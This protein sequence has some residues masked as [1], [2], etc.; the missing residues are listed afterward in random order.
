M[1]RI[2]SRV[3][4]ISS[5]LSALL[6]IVVP[7]AAQ[8]PSDAA[9]F[10]TL[11]TM[12]GPIP[13]ADRAQPANL[14]QA[15]DLDIL[16][17]AGDG[18]VGQLAR[19]GVSATS[20]DAV[21]ISHL[22]FDHT[23]GLLAL[24]GLYQQI[25]VDRELSIYG[26]PGTGELVRGLL[27]AMK[28]AAE[29]GPGLPNYVARTPGEHIRTVELSDGESVSIGKARL[30]VAANSHYSYPPGSADAKR[31]QSLSLR[32]D[33][34]GRSIVY[35]GD[36]GPSTAVEKLARGADLLVCEI[37]DVDA[38]MASLRKARPSMPATQ[39]E[40]IRPHF[41]EQHLV[42]DEIGLLASRARVG[43]LV[44]THNPASGPEAI[45]AIRRHF[46]GPVALASDLDRF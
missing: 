17:D 21:V 44:I 10:V 20:I 5:V 8:P 29:V 33:L 34:P 18:A 26:P 23:A 43:Q 27:I 24:L 2:G 25:G 19:A 38:A 9:S 6:L 15:G 39:V 35:T 36:T 46:S 11:G 42:A 4:T 16:V 3:S 32:F 13:S 22:H 37:V 41:A 31:F 12:G 40:A 7:A 28:P 1:S 45:A 30:T 14:L